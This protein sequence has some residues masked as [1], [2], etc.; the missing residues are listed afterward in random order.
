ML[1]AKEI[2]KTITKNY[3]KSK[4]VGYKFTVD[5]LQDDL[6]LT[7][8][9]EDPD[10]PL[11]HSINDTIHEITRKRSLKEIG[12]LIKKIDKSPKYSRQGRRPANLYQICEVANA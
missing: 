4:P 8:D 6:Y 2:I 9:I 10:D 1:K 5:N 11:F 3:I 7:P 12:I